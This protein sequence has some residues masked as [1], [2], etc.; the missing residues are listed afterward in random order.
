MNRWIV[1]ESEYPDDGSTEV[2][3]WTEK[4]A[5]RKY[6]RMTGERNHLTDLT[7]LSVE[8]IQ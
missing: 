2:E 8:A 4:G 6:R 5:R 3:A 7:P 1:W